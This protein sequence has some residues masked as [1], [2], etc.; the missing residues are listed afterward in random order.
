MRILKKPSDL[1]RDHP[2]R[3]VA[4]EIV[5]R[6]GP[7]EGYVV[8]IAPEDLDQDL[9]LPELPIRLDRVDW[10][11]VSRHP[12]YFHAVHLTNNE[13]AISFLIPDSVDGP[14]RESLQIWVE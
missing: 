9:P 7:G 8:L 12:G 3:E 14:L 4:A 1:P 2:A 5:S 11:G 13:F 6:I 10:E